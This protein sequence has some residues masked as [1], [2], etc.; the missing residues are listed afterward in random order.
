MLLP[1]RLF[2]HS[3]VASFTFGSSWQATL[4]PEANAQ[5]Y[6][7]LF[8]ELLAI[9]L[10]AGRYAPGSTTFHGAFAGVVGV[11]GAL[12][13]PTRHRDYRMVYA[14]ST[15]HRGSNSAIDSG[16]IPESSHWLISQRLT[17]LRS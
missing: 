7:R 4:A 14:I 17:Q 6:A 9:C 3:P 11:F 15:G 5:A 10:S 1:R 2:G 8:M 13:W 16:R 12:M